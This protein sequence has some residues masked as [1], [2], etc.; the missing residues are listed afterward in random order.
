MKPTEEIEY[1]RRF[2]KSMLLVEDNPGDAN[3]VSLALKGTVDLF[4]VKCVDSL[5]AAVTEL[6]KVRYG[7]VIFDLGLP[8]GDG[9]DVVDSI[10]NAAGDSA[11]VVLTGRD[12]EELGVLAIQHGADDYFVKSELSA[13]GLQRSINYA[14]E[15][16]RSKVQARRFSAIV[17]SSYDAIISKD[18]SLVIT[19]WNTGAE[20]LY[21]YTA[22]EAVGQSI[23][24]LMPYD[25][26][27]EGL[28]ILTRVSERE[29]VDNFETIRMRKDGTLVEVSL[30]VSPLLGTAREVVGASIIGRDISDR[31]KAEQ[32]KDKLLETAQEL[33]AI[34]ESSADGIVTMD[35]EGTILTWNR[36]AQDLYGYSAEEAI[37]Q[38]MSFLDIDAAFET[39]LSA[40]T[41]IGGSKTIRDLE[42]VRR[43]RDGTFVD[44]SLS[45]S[46]IY[47]DDG[48]VIGIASIGR[49][50]SDRRKAE[51][52][53]DEFLALVSHE[54]RTPLA[55]IV[56]HAELLLDDGPM[57]DTRR[58]GFLEVIDRNSVRLERLV[59][60]LLLVAQL[61][62]D[63]LSLSMID[64]DI[65][66]VVKEA[67]ETMSLRARQSDIEITL[68][69]EQPSLVLK[70][71][72]GRL[73]QA[74][75]NLISNAI[76]YSPAG[77]E[78]AVRILAVNDRC[79]VEIEDHGIGIATEELGLLFDR[80]FRGSTATSLH[81]QGVGLGLLI[82][83]R[84]IEE[85]GG[86]VTVVSEAGVGTTFSV[87]LPIVQSDPVFRSLSLPSSQGRP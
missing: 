26:V 10:R 5:Q 79:V 58:R 81:I 59:G 3:L 62:S 57:E 25:H 16:A 86:D 69:S 73:G 42:L 19:S 85:H 6:S 80:F 8:D 46:P 83:K 12:D 34:V 27:D 7:C 55:S 18:L 54:L 30:R 39:R 45:G 75:D 44:V 29:V 40:M 49:D 82:V 53:K 63:H 43:R 23:T 87:V 77:N 41:A 70:G 28:D 60:D 65:V 4:E 21:G 74:I 66:E 61:E 11:L 72:P 22:S 32:L 37:G 17:E 68:F 78:V 31:R 1:S 24:M 20:R 51:Q 52:L 47:S 64:I 13:R 50:I 15:R 14:I 56:A 71:D 38:N 35:I 76:K 84:I 2:P 48:S 33:S 36:G 9:L 67:I